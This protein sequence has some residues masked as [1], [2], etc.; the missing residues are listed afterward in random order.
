MISIL[1]GVGFVFR[2]GD[3]SALEGTSILRKL[4]EG[5]GQIVRVTEVVGKRFFQMRL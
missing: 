2:L 4:T 3:C 5:V 1:V